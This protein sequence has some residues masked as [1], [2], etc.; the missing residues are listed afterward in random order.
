[1]YVGQ[2]CTFALHALLRLHV[3]LFWRDDTCCARIFLWP[4]RGKTIF[5]FRTPLQQLTR[6]KTTTTTV[7]V[8]LLTT[9]MGWCGRG[10]SLLPGALCPAPLLSSHI[11][12]VTE[13]DRKYV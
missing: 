9:Y 1:M 7:S 8:Y 6:G 2:L 5:T 4:A 11:L 3:P 13:R 10:V 12:T